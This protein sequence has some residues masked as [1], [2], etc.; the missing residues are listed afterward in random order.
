MSK[1]D[2]EID[3]LL[4]DIRVNELGDKEKGLVASDKVRL[5]AQGALLNYS[6][7][8]IAGIK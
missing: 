4:D 7:E 8:A 6:D 3:G 2:D 1:L 5:I